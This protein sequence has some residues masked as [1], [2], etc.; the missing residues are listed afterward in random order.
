MGEEWVKEEWAEFGDS[1][2]SP[3]AFSDGPAIW[4]LATS[5]THPQPQFIKLIFPTYKPLPEAVDG[6]LGRAAGQTTSAETP[7]REGSGW[8]LW[9]QGTRWRSRISEDPGWGKPGSIWVPSGKGKNPSQK[10][11]PLQRCRPAQSP[12]L[13]SFPSH[14]LDQ[15]G[16]VICRPD[17]LLLRHKRPVENFDLESQNYFEI[18]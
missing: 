11:K 9:G 1:H 15:T 18:I 6:G 5:M 8:L 10:N 4:T 12:D 14:T 7:G 13:H 16:V 2:P 17:L 3:I